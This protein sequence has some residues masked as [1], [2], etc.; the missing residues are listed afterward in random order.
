MTVQ[1]GGVAAK[2]AYEEVVVQLVKVFEK[3]LEGAEQ[4]GT[5]SGARALGACVGGMVL[6]RNVGD[7][8]WP[9]TCAAP[10]MQRCCRR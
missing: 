4:A 10:R 3:H 9:T 5:R 1:R 7:R 8:I 2:A 6:A